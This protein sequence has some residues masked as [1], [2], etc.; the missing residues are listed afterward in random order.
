[1]IKT[2]W[3]PK[4]ELEYSL[5]DAKKISILACNGC[6]AGCATG[7]AVGMLILKDILEKSGKEVVFTDTVMFCCVEP[8]LQQTMTANHEAISGSDALVMDS[9]PSGA[10]AAFLCDP[11]IPVVVALDSVGCSVLSMQD[12]IVARSI[13]NGCGQC[14]ITYTGGICPVTEC[15]LKRKYEPCKKAPQK[16]TQCAEKPDQKCVWKE[17]AKRGN[18]DV[19]KKLRGIHKSSTNKLSGS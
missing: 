2:V 5:R 14:V 6:A 12:D 7:G 19:L 9:C 15:P 8:L 1:V 18:L 17:I 3:K 4:E 13:C 10:K 16:G 11:G